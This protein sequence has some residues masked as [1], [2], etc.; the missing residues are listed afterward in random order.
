[1]RCESEQSEVGYTEH[2]EDWCEG[3]REGDIRSERAVGVRERG[4]RCEE[5]DEVTW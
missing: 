1:M 5:R 3:Q 4:V 2:A